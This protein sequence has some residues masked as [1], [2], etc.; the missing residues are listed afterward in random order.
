M[1][2]GLIEIRGSA[3]HGHGGFAVTDIPS[4]TL[5]LEYVGQRIDKAE[6][7]RRC[8]MDNRFIFC[9]D[10]EWDLDG[11]TPDNPARFVN[12]SCHPN[13]EA[14]G[15]AGQI[16]LVA[17]RPIRAGEEIT[18]NYG[19]DLENCREHPCHCG[20]ANCVGFIVAE[21]Y[22]DHVRQQSELRQVAA[23]E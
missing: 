14:Q 1:Q 2:N 19:Y 23:T 4:G 5:V 7:L 9:L 10:D 6:A 16:W 11:D 13:C 12:H 3:I 15:I 18:F 8:E 17:V 22:F 20:A 21:E